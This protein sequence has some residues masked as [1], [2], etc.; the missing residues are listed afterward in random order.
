MVKLALNQLDFGVAFLP[1][2]SS[3][4]W[5]KRIE[6]EEGTKGWHSWGQCS[7]AIRKICDIDEGCEVHRAID[8]VENES[9][10]Q[11]ILQDG[12]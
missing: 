6:L 8:G 1:L 11:T 9:V 7:N 5:V 4:G 12:Q 10:K 3:H 2:T